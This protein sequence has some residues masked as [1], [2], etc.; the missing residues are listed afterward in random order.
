ME[1]HMGR[2]VGSG[3]LSAVGSVISA[4]SEHGRG[5]F[6]SSWL[7]FSL[8]VGEDDTQVDL[9]SPPNG[10]ASLASPGPTEVEY[11]WLFFGPMGCVLQGCGVGCQGCP[12]LETLFWHMLGT[13]GAGQ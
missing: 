1:P 9:C 10:T 5:S 2:A 4:V 13:Q 7:L 11:I 8:G 6:M 12:L 3:S